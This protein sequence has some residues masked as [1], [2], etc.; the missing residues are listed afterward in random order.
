MHAFPSTDREELR[1]L[2]ADDVDPAAQ[3]GR[4]PHIQVHGGQGN[5]LAPRHRRRGAALVE[6][7]DVL[8]LHENTQA[9]D[10]MASSARAHA[11]LNLCAA[12]IQRP[13]VPARV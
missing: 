1:G 13:V 2:E 7:D 11:A 8:D 12:A 3:R 4:R 10:A 5:R 9:H 6:V